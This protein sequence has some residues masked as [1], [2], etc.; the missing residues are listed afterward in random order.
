M[1]TGGERGVS[2]R[3]IWRGVKG[4]EVGGGANVS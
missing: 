2:Q 3:W 4:K 1:G